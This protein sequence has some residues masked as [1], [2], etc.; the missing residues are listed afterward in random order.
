M[1]T[2]SKNKKNIILLIVTS[3]PQE[4]LDEPINPWI[5]EKVLKLK[6]DF[7]IKIFTSAFKGKTKTQFKEIKKIY[8]FRYFP[9][10]YEDLTHKISVLDKLKENKKNWIKVFLFLISGFLNSIY[11]TLK[12]NFDIIH[13]HWPLPLALFGIVPK[14]LKNKPLIYTFHSAGLNIAQ[15]YTILKLI[16]R[17]LLKFADAIT[18]NSTFTLKQLEKTA[19]KNLLKNKI[20]KIIPFSGTLKENTKIDLSKKKKKILFVGRFV[21]RK[22]IEYLVKAFA[23]IYKKD[24]CKDWMLTLAGRKGPEKEKILKLIEELNLKNRVSI[25]FELNEEE[26][27]QEYAESSIFVLPSIIDRKGDTEGLGTVLIEAGLYKNALI[28]SNVGGIPDIIKHGE[29]GLLVPQKDVNKLA[30]AIEKLIKNEELRKK[31]AENAHNYVKQNF[32]WNKIIE[33]FKKLYKELINKTQKH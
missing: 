6:D 32:S 14:F 24:S 5:T 23:K 11:F 10:Q 31:L 30:D 21:E 15:K 1:Q 27:K 13:V 25:K 16:L 33:E 4:K 8:R 17:I 18:V 9:S 26:K 28:G 29:T 7:E 22:G 12:E 19:T 3:F 20:I 2:K